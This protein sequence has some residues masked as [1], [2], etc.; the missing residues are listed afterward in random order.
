MKKISQYIIVTFILPVYI[1]GVF[2]LVWP[3]EI[4][5]EKENRM[6]ARLPE[7][8]WSS[9]AS[10]SFSTEF[11]SWFSDHFP[12]RDA[13]IDLNNKTSNLMKI[14]FDK[15]N[16]V[17]VQGP[18]NDLGSG[19]FLVHD[20]TESDNSEN[21]THAPASSVDNNST[22][23]SE[24]NLPGPT[25]T[26]VLPPDE[27]TIETV[28]TEAAEPVIPPPVVDAPV[29]DYSAV[30][31][32]N[33][34][35]MEL[36]GFN[37]TKADRYISLINKLQD[38][39]PL[40]QVYNIVAPTSI[41]FYAPQ[42]Y[43]SLSSSQK[44]AIEYIYSG[45]SDKVRKV[46][47]YSKLYANWQDYIYFRSDHHW[48]ALGAYYGYEAFAQ[49]AGLDTVPLANFT[50]GSVPGDFLG[51][52]Y[53]YTQST[54]LKNS[55]DT[56][57]YYEPQTS[58]EGLAFQSA[59]LVD[60]RKIQ[61]IFKKASIGNQ[62]LAFIEG[63][64]PIARFTTNLNNNKKVLVIKESYGNAFVPFLANH[65]E[66]I[67]VIDPRKIS[68]NLPEFIFGNQIQDIVIINYSFAVG[69]KNWVDGFEKM[70]G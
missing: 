57:Y 43:S 55:P 8:S 58:A 6:L 49:A 2:H 12:F 51:S 34:Q 4:I 21:S 7:I 69:N 47:A 64:H 17:L 1:L 48:T 39:L 54:D 24:N 46:D 56:V 38:K 62:Y 16:V 36:F 5:S 66:E 67:Y 50:K 23:P 40:S 3:D 41:E 59:E 68:M 27:T 61:L 35:A 65:Y 60:G 22:E 10:G 18:A 28:E 26:D 20:E 42:K 44:S 70:I 15:D 19:E 29:E 14:S 53:R 52:L 11:E 31:I 25:A 13:L 32:V 30:I 45:L 37:Q 9:I 63:D 33:N